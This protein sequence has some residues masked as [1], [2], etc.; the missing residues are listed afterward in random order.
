MMVQSRQLVAHSL[1]FSHEAR[2]IDRNTG[3]R[4]L[5]VLVGWLLLADLFAGG[6]SI[7]LSLYG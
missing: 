2:V 7:L 3:T 1:T 5:P 4:G 6:Y